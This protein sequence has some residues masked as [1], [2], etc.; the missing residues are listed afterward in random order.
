M[1][2]LVRFVGSLA[3][4]NEPNRERVLGNFALREGES[5]LSVWHT[6]SD[7]E[8]ELVLG[9]RCLHKRRLEAVT[10][11]QFAEEVARTY[12]PITITPG[13]SPL[14][15]INSLHRELRWSGEQL[16]ALADALLTSG[17]K[18]ARMQK[19][20]VKKVLEEI[21]AEDFTA[22]ARAWVLGGFQRS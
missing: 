20:A 9:A 5:G 10:Y 3:A 21:D 4:W 13:D 8:R 17:V 11:I 19:G 14:G 12:G 22:P 7:R 16:V 1:A 2:L 15:I 18:A 6:S